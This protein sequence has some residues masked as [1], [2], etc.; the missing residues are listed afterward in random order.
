MTLKDVL[1]AL[2]KAGRV[3]SLKELYKLAGG[4]HKGPDK[5]FH[6]IVSQNYGTYGLIN[7]T[8]RDYHFYLTKKGEAALAGM[9]D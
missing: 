3:N 4:I 9:K 2:K 7:T 8:S 6:Q 1:T 5:E